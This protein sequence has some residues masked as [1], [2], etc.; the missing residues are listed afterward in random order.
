MDKPKEPKKPSLW[1][2]IL[3]SKVVAAVGNAI[4]QSKFGQ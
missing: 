1:Q 4:G 3:N 2:R